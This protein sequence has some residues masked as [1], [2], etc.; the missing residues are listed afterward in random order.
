MGQAAFTICEP[1]GQVKFLVQ[2]GSL[3]QIP[4]SLRSDKQMDIELFKKKWWIKK[5]GFYG[6]L[7]FLL[8]YKV[9]SLKAF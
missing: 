4:V 3:S 5:Y 2:L 6:R 7:I 1:A 8:W 9:K